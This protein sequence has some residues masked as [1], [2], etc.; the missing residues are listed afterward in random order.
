MNEL[1]PEF[2]E[3][4]KVLASRFEIP[5][6][7][8]LTLLCRILHPDPRVTCGP[9]SLYLHRV[10][11]GENFTFLTKDQ[12]EIVEDEQYLGHY[13]FHYFWF[14]GRPGRHL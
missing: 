7:L 8:S 12:C 13:N 14:V 2:L 11:G 1:Q 6:V 4:V 3:P 9:M 5:N 10:G